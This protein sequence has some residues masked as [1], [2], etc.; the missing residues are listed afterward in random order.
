VCGRSTRPLCGRCAAELPLAA[1]RP[2]PGALE[3]LAGLLDYRDQVRR[4]VA[5]AK[6]RPTGPLADLLGRSLG[7]LLTELTA[8]EPSELH[9]SSGEPVVVTWAPT[10]SSRARRRGGDQAEALAR[11]AAQ[12]TSSFVR[13][14]PTLQRIGRGRQV[15]RDRVQRID[16]V[17][18]VA[19][20]GSVPAGARVVVVDDVCTTGAT[21]HAAGAALLD[22]GA[23]R[24][25]GL[26]LA[27]RS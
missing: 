27:V 12:E 17:R 1:P 14:V 7:P 8:G 16:G 25:D 2:P 24:V 21:L 13:V 9:R 6:L 10:V 15:G 5:A 23:A 26:V 19:Q 18:F 4:I 11:A 22:A 3:R 20:P